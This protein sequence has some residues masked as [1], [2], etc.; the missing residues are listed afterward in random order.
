M[1]LPP[2]RAMPHAMG[3]PPTA[4]QCIVYLRSCRRVGRCPTLWACR[5]HRA[6]TANK[7][8]FWRKILYV[9]ITTFMI[10]PLTKMNFL[11][12]VPLSHFCTVS[13]ATTAALISA[14]AMSNANGIFARTLPLIDI[15]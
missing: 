3:V 7:Y 1:L 5:P 14:S 8:I 13:S 4:N 6:L 10:R 11:G 12:S 9:Y 2:R 15:G